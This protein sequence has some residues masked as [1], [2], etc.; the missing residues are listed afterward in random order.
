MKIFTVVLCEKC[1]DL[2]LRKLLIKKKIL[3]R[4][5]QILAA[6]VGGLLGVVTFNPFA[7]FL[8]KESVGHSMTD[9]GKR[10]DEFLPDPN[11]LFSQDPNSFFVLV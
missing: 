11:L 3:Q 9:K 6:L 10:V 1:I 8:W 2:Q 5:M 4:R 7:P